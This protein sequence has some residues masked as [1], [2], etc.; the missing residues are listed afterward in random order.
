MSC[1]GKNRFGYKAQAVVDDKAGS[2]AQWTVADSGYG[3][4]ADIQQAAQHKV[5]V[6]VQP[7]GDAAAQSKPCHAHHFQYEAA[8]DRVTCPQRKELS[9]AR[10]M[11]Q[12]GQ[13]VRVYRCDQEDCPVRS[14]CTKEL[15]ARRFVEIWA[16][17]HRRA[18]RC[19]RASESLRQPGICAN[20]AR[21]LSGCLRRSNNTKVFAVGQ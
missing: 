14:A 3:S 21:S 15:R 17:H 7:L 2:P 5:P 8:A 6:L 10:N 4:G 9:F 13:T 12:K 1:D 18:T 16:A 20:A 19:E 11:L